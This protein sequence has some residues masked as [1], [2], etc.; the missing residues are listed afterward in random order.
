MRIPQVNGSVP[1]ASAIDPSSKQSVSQVS[2]VKAV[3]EV[4]QAVPD[5]AQ[6]KQA[7][8]SINKVMQKFSH[9]LRFSVDGD[10]GKVVVKVVDT[11]TNDV[12]RQIPN[13][14]VLAISKALDKLQGLIIRQKA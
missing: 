12:I 10:T 4:K 7:A 11:K 14:E 8:D 6:I 1:A 9:N 13:E 5:E 2:Q 3:S